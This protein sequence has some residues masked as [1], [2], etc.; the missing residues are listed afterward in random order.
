MMRPI[1]LVIMDGIGINPDSSGNAVAEANTP[2]LDGLISTYPSTQIWA[3]G[4]HVGLP[5]GQMGNSEVGHLNIGAGRIVYQDFT[6]ISKAISSGEFAKNP[7]ILQIIDKTKKSGKALHLMGL[8]SDGGV[9]SHIDH[10]FA[11]I[12]LAK[13]Q[14]IQKLFIHPFM[15]GRDTPPRSGKGYIEQLEKY[16]DAKGVGKIATVM[17]RFYAMDRDNRWERVRLAYEA[18]V[19]GGDH[20]AS[21]SLEAMEG[22]YAEDNGD[23]FVLPTLVDGE[24]LVGDGDSMI[25]FNFRA[26]RAREITRAFTEKKFKAF[27]DIDRPE[28]GSYLCLTEYDSAFDLPVAFPATSLKN[29][30]GQVLSRAGMKQLRIAETEKYAHVTFFFNGG[31]EKENKGEDRILIPSPKE[32]RTY[33]EKPSMSAPEVTDRVV[34]ALEARKYDL[35][36]LNYANGDM[37][38]HTGVFEATVEAVETVDNCIGR[39]FEAAKA[40]NYRVLITADHGNADQMINPKTGQPHTAHSTNPVKFILADDSMI[41]GKLRSEGILA[42]I[43]P[44]ILDLLDMEKPVDMDGSSLIIPS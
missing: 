8:L 25:F 1:I 32:V 35:I 23:E 36:V 38:G 12:D 10:L 26:D 22:S 7:E 18:M 11:F 15:D 37:V 40:G 14:G 20:K 29:T 30:L 5:D 33:D 2:I 28:I 27:G 4:R 19:K 44:T 16:L 24:G 43:A 41:N 34:E 6:R 13:K 42:D 21:S 17:G 9:H 39:L 31:E 3:S